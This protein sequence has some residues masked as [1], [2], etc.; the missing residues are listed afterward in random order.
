MGV[1]FCYFPPKEIGFIGELQK[2]AEREG[3]CDSIR[4]GQSR[5]V[6]SGFPR[7]LCTGER[8]R[9]C[10]VTPAL[11]LGS[12]LAAEPDTSAVL[13]NQRSGASS[14]RWF[15]VDFL[16]ELQ[17]PYLVCEPPSSVELRNSAPS[18]LC[19]FKH[20]GLG[21]PGVKDGTSLIVTSF[22]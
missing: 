19:V 18:L 20:V 16:L 17:V 15:L 2:R 9:C 22:S 7:G 13:R 3:F 4:T 5:A 12:L 14:G 21:P 8:G 6:L 10:L 11:A 1:S